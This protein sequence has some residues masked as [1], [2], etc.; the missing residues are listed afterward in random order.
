MPRSSVTATS[1]RVSRFSTA[2][3]EIP[4]PNT[5]APS[6]RPRKIVP[7]LAP[8]FSASSIESSARTPSPSCFTTSESRYTTQARASRWFSS[9]N[10][11]SLSVRRC[12]ARSRMWVTKAGLPN[13][14]ESNAVIES[15]KPD[16]AAKRADE[17]L[18]FFGVM[19]QWRHHAP[20]RPRP[21]GVAGA[22]LDDVNVQLR[23]QIA[24]GGDI[25]LVASR[26][27]LQLA[28]CAGDFGHQL[29][30]RHLVEV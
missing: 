7:G 27:V 17:G 21:C 16:L 12:A 9:A 22:P 15:T 8:K 6:R 23:H 1:L 30:L 26:D 29:R 4:M 11:F 18:H 20:H 13:G 28:G 10:S 2:A 5:A 24:E 25:Q 14:N 19:R 3:A